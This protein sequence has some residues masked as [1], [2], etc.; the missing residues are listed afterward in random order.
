MAWFVFLLGKILWRLAVFNSRIQIVVTTLFRWTTL[1]DANFMD[2]RY[3]LG[4]MYT[5]QKRW[6]D[7]LA[8]YRKI[9]AENHTPPLT[10]YHHEG[11]AL[12]RLGRLDESIASCQNGIKLNTNFSWRYHILGETYLKK[13]IGEWA[14]WYVR[15]SEL[16]LKIEC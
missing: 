5:R 13:T 9:L 1:L 2:A 4:L 15:A 3:H 12:L 11:E 14:N 8:S 10:I 6:R 7:A 16:G